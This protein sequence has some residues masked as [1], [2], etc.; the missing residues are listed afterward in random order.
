MKTHQKMYGTPYRF[1]EED[2]ADGTS[3][4]PSDPGR[5]TR[6]FPSSEHH[7]YS[8]CWYEN[9]PTRSKEEELT[10]TLSPSSLRPISFK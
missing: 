5:S 3:F 6:Q 2:A 9:A 4:A 7:R 8:E 1:Q 10:T